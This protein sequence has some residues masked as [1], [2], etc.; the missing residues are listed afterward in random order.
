MRRGFITV[1][2]V[3]AMVLPATPVRAGSSAGTLVFSSV[4]GSSRSDTGLYT[5]PAGG[6]TETKFTGTNGAY[7]PGGRRT[8]A[9]WPISRDGTSGGSTRTAPTTICCWGTDV[10]PAHHANLTT[11]QVPYGAQPPLPSMPAASRRLYRVVLANK[12]FPVVLGGASRP[13]RPRPRVVAGRGHAVTRDPYGSHRN[14]IDGPSAQWLR[15]SPDAS[16]LVFQ[17]EVKHSERSSSW[18]PTA[19]TRRT[20]RTPRPTTGPP[21]G[22]RTAPGATGPGARRP[23]PRQPVRDGSGRLE[24][25]AADVDGGSST[26]TS[27][28]GRPER[29]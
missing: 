26:S 18:E 10:L 19:R 24:L 16:M 28:T 29:R 6:G 21:A 3:L 14:E 15:W 9:V 12:R 13:S 25:D 8:G 4:F 2:L 27:R 1:G 22:R 5:M 23:G 7:R 11:T 20:S 17:R